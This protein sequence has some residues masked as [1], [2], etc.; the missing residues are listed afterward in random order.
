MSVLVR[1]GILYIDLR[2]YLPNGKKKHTC[3]STGKK[4]NKKNRR[5]IVERDKNIQYELK[6]NTFEYLRHFPNGP[7]AHLFRDKKSNITFGEV[8]EEWLSVKI[9]KRS[10]EDTYNCTYRNYIEEP[11][12]NIPI[13]QIDDLYI[14]AFR[15]DLLEVRGLQASTINDKIMKMLKMVFKYAFKKDYIDKNPCEDIRRLK[16]RKVDVNPLSIDECRYLIGKLKEKNKDE[17]ADLIEIWI[18]TGLRPGE[19]Y[20]LKW[21]NVDFYNKKILV[22]ETRYK[23]IDYD[24]KTESSNR[25]VFL[26]KGPLA[27][28]MRQK[29]RTFMKGSYVFLT[30]DGKPFS[31]AFMRKKFEHIFKLAG[32]PYRPPRQM[33]HTFASLHIQASANPNWVSKT[34]GHSSLYTTLKRYNRFIPSKSQDEGSL[35]EAMMNSYQDAEQESP[36]QIVGNL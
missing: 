1:N 29:E 26:K 18:Y 31:D 9:L 28:I 32:L 15:K 14:N 17:W 21:N 34:L 6:N 13:S 25:E 36:C 5:K 30:Q 12:A 19:M 8:H 33:R 3:L 4:D 24:P 16:E 27:A 11:F 20:A 23:G 2:F 7:D 35:F 10:T 22:R